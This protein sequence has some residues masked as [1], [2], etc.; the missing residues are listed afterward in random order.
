MVF[1]VRMLTYG[2][3]AANRIVPI[4]AGR[5]GACPYDVAGVVWSRAW[6][7]VE[8]GEKREG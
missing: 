5:H 3:T 7:D 2:G 6:K 8:C 1:M 4:V